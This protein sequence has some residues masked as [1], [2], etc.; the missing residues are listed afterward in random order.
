MCLVIYIEE[1]LV[2]ISYYSKFYDYSVSNDGVKEKHGTN[3]E[4]D[5]FTDV[6]KREA[7]Q[8]IMNV[9]QTNG[10][11]DAP[12]FMYI[13]TPAPHRPATPAPQYEHRYDGHL[14]PRTPSYNYNTT[15]KH[16]LISNG[17]CTIKVYCV[18]HLSTWVAGTPPMSETTKM[19][20][21]TLYQ[22]RLETLLSVD[23]LVDEVVSTLE[24][25]VS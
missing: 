4:K 22:D 24:V 1:C 3:Y 21:D 10:D 2:I 15:D 9:T 7:V 14:A 12:F 19:I 5:Y 20:V 23:D 8:F 18:A 16:W 6:I 11:D 17:Q 25:H 13:A